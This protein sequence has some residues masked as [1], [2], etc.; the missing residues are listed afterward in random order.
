MMCDLSPITLLLTHS[1]KQASYTLLRARLYSVSAPA[2]Q[3]TFVTVQTRITDHQRFPIVEEVISG[4]RTQPHIHDTV[5]TVQRGRRLHR[6]LIFVK[7]HRLLP[8]NAAIALLVPGRQ[9]RGDILVMRIGTSVNGVVNMRTGDRR[10]VD[11]AVQWYSPQNL[12]HSYSLTFL[13]TQLRSAHI[14]RKAASFPQ[15]SRIL[16]LKLRNSILYKVPIKSYAISSTRNI[17]TY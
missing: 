11:Y 12:T 16:R 17:T 10:L 14:S 13:P 6:F 1:V 4:M 2:N 9:W 15:T 7:N 8:L 3:P 5:L